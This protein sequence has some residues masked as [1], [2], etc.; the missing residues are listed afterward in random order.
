M[1]G[2]AKCKKKLPHFRSWGLCSPVLLMKAVS[3]VTLLTWG[4]AQR[5]NWCQLSFSLH[6]SLNI[7]LQRSPRS[8]YFVGSPGLVSAVVNTDEKQV[9]EGAYFI[10]QLRVHRWRLQDRNPKKTVKQRWQRRSAYWL[11]Q[12]PFL[13]SSDAPARLTG[14]IKQP[15][16]SSETWP[17]TS[18]MEAKSQLKV[19]LHR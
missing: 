6:L 15:E 7:K 14:A 17:H 10:L 9:Q 4:S 5:S 1:P 12:L 19:L 8:L 18:L 16:N 13:R 2:L 3:G 11:T